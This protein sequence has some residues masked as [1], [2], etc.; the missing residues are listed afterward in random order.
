MTCWRCKEDPQPGWFASPRKCAFPDGVFTSDNWNCATMSLVR[1]KCP[2]NFDDHGLIYGDEDEYCSAKYIDLD[3]ETFPA[4]G[5]D[6]SGFLVLQ[7]YK[8]RG[9]VTGAVV[10]DCDGGH[11]EFTLTMADALLMS[12]VSR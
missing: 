10:M 11:T 2:G 9:R 8:R 1:Y 7:W 4:L 12:E 5:R 3:G 6:V